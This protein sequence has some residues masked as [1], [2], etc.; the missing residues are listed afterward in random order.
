MACITKTR[1]IRRICA[2]SLDKL[3]E[4]KA[5]K[6][7]APNADTVDYGLEF[8][9]LQKVWAMLE[10]VPNVAIFDGTNTERTVSHLWYIRY[11]PGITFENWLKFKEQYF[12]IVTVENFEERDE[13][14]LLRCNVRGDATKP[15]NFS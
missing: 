6:I 4:I 5:R 11:I 3:I 10:T 15:A 9:D 8:S 13:F 14:Y 7:K 1:R 12:D 2:G